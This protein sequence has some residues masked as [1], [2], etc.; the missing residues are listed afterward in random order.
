MRILLTSAAALVAGG[1]LLGLGAQ[2]AQAGPLPV[3]T[4]LTADTTAVQSVG[5]RRR[6][7][8]RHRVWPTGPR[9]AVED[10]YGNVIIAAPGEPVII[11][12]VRPR[13]CG[14]YRFWN[15]Y[16]CVDA[17]YNDTDLGPR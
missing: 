6:Y 9:P 5:W 2:G 16:A 3:M 11:S 10:S 1:L 7:Y 8:R 13:S 14:Q 4:S 12:P 17:R 15:G